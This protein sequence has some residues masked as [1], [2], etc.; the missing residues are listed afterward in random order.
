MTPEQRARAWELVAWAA[1]KYAG[2]GDDDEEEDRYIQGK[3][4][5]HLHA[6]AKALRRK[7]RAKDPRNK[8]DAEP[9]I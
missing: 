1:E 9:E 2:Y 3:I 7:E 6:K 4:I 5:P 8:T